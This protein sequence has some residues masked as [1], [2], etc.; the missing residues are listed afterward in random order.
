MGDSPEVPIPQ[1]D[2]ETLNPEWKESIR[3]G[4]VTSLDNA[5]IA[6]EETD[7]S[8]TAPLDFHPLLITEGLD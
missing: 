2:S 1:E 5:F 8:P 7:E 3:E 6:F 4:I